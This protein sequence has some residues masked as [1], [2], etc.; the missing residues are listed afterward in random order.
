MDGEGRAPLWLLPEE[1][2]ELPPV[3]EDRTGLSLVLG[4]A[5]L[6]AAVPA[7]L[8]LAPESTCAPESLLIIL[9]ILAF[10]SYTAAVKV[11]DTLTLD[12]SFVPALL[13]G[14]RSGGT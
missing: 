12:A 6:L 1:P 5:T 10:V 8:L 9:L 11:R 3:R 2:R 13:A 14:T 7:F 4:L